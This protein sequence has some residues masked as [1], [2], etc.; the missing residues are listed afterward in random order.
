M[1][2]HEDGRLA[3]GYRVGTFI[4][5]NAMKNSEM[6]ILELSNLKPNEILKLSRLQ[7]K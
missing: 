6:T 3:I 2:Q 1:N 7:E 5:E 4:V